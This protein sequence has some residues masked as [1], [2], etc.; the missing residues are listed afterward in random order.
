MKRRTFPRSMVVLCA[1]VL[2]T[3][4]PGSGCP[5]DFTPPTV[6]LVPT[7]N[8]GPDKNAFIG[9]TVTL[10]GNA[11]TDQDGDPL[12][13]TWSQTQ[14][15]QVEITNDN[16][17]Q[18]SF[19][20]ERAGDYE[21]V[22]TVEDGRGGSDQDTVKVAIGSAAPDDDPSK[23]TDE[24][25]ISDSEDNCPSV[26]NDDQSDADGDGKGD[27]CDPTPHG[28]DD[29]DKD[30]A[31]NAVAKAAEEA[32]VGD[33]VQLDA[34]ESSDPEGGDLTFEWTQIDGPEATIDNNTDIVTFFDAAE[35]GDYAFLLTVTDAAGNTSTDTVRIG[36]KE[37]DE[38]TDE[39]GV[40]GN[41]TGTV[42]VNGELFDSEGTSTQIDPVEDTFDVDIFGGTV[43]FYLGFST[44]EEEDDIVY[45]VE[46]IGD[47][48]N[49]DTADAS[50]YM[51]VTDI[52]VGEFGVFIQFY[53]ERVD[54]L[55]GGI[56]IGTD[57]VFIEPVSETSLTYAEFFSFDVLD[58][59][60]FETV[61]TGYL[62]SRGMLEPVEF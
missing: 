36:V 30:D 60:T 58:P 47:T 41:W 31:P 3:L 37:E 39:F 10:N 53:V 45:S 57:E 46:A 50:V 28:D 35:A 1:A 22:V 25:G 14:G 38:P 62:E 32:L 52:S 27:A 23:D 55:I 42:E 18:A 26:A 11:S 56:F 7:A 40:E 24:D 54:S 20:A 59:E 8:A 51:E 48:V 17:P 2:V 21:F 16:Q 4:L 49:F 44:P 5:T 34:T 12:S 9:D 33:Q 29:P 6:N 43:T 13:F 19:V 61:L 15:P